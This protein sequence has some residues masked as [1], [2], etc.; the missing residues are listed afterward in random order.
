M[1]HR[2]SKSE[3]EI[4]FIRETEGPAG[5]FAVFEDDGE[6]GYLYLYEPEGR[7]IFQHLNIYNR[8]SELRIE[9]SDVE[10]GWSEDLTA[11]S[12]WIRGKLNGTIDLPRI[13][14]DQT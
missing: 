3:D 5:I 14:I 8:T 2:D 10:V 4:G 9:K 1:T 11:C 7:G 13:I 6:T 12:V